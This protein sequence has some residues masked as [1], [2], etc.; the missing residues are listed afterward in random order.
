LFYG[1]DGIS[2][3]IIKA[4]KALHGIG[5]NIEF[6]KYFKG[7]KNFKHL[8]VQKFVVKIVLNLQPWIENLLKRDGNSVEGLALKMEFLAI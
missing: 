1:V 3:H 8:W 2:C 4:R 7:S 5:T 6:M